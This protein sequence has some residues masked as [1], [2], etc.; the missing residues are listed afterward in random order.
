[1]RWSSLLS[2]PGDEVFVVVVVHVIFIVVAVCIP[3]TIMASLVAPLLTHQ[4]YLAILAH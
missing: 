1:M 2:T 3:A 4:C